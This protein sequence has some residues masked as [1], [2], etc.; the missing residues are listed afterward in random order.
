MFEAYHQ[1]V[2]AEICGCFEYPSTEL[3]ELTSCLDDMKI[4]YDVLNFLTCHNL[5][6]I[7]SDMANT[8]A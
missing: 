2:A 3:D 5:S 7:R 1:A 8:F 4:G 6:P